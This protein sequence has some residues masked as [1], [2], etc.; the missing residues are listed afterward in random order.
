M[1]KN[2]KRPSELCCAGGRAVI[3]LVNLPENSFILYLSILVL[4]LKYL[5]LWPVL[6]KHPPRKLLRLETTQS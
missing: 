2:Q 5:F 3:N 1:L 4:S 6:V